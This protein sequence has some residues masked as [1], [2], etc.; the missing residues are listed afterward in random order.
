MTTHDASTA[1]LFVPAQRQQGSKADARPSLTYW[2]DAWIRLRRNP[3][4]LGS[5]LFLGILA[6][7]AWLGP[8]AL[9]Y[10]YDSQE[11]W[12][13]HAPPGLGTVVHV[14]PDDTS[15]F[16]SG[17]EVGDSDAAPIPEGS[18]DELAETLPIV[19]GARVLGTPYTTGVALQWSPTPGAAGYRVYRS[20]SESTLGLP[21]AEVPA[22]ATRYTD[23]GNLTGGSTYH[24]RIVA[25]NAWTESEPSTSLLAQPQLALPYGQARDLD[26]RAQVGSTI[27]LPPHYLGTDY[28]GRDI[29]A[30]LLMGARIS[31]LI[32]ILAPL[33]YVAIG[34]IYGS[35]AGFFGGLVDDLLMRFADIMYTI[36]ELLT[37]ILLQVVL[38]SGPGTLILALV[39][40]AWARSARQIRGQVLQLREMEFVQAARILGT[41]LP[42]IIRLHLVPNVMGTV[43][44]FFTLSIPQ[45]IFTEAFLSFIGLGIAP[46]LASWGTITREGAKFFLTYPRELIIPG[47]VICITMLAFNLLGDGLRDALDPRLRGQR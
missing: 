37:V 33:I 2:Q 15:A 44:V 31:L 38:G 32:G 9:P 30:R 16:E 17:T 39:I 14:V 25:Y 45:A 8:L 40:S 10:T 11:V 7:A 47:G 26:A 46:P 4:A 36:P 20:I 29:L 24:Y 34:V 18:G 35:I 42:Q 28:L 23:S 27:S 41:S 6:L 1:S 13:S 3:V 43:L 12:N 21:M 19:E 22:T 5:G